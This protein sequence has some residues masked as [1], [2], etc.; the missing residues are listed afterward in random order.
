M[1]QQRKKWFYFKDS[2][3]AGSGRRADCSLCG[4][5]GAAEEE[6]ASSYAMSVKCVVLTFSA[7]F[8]VCFLQV[9][10]FVCF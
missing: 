9:L 3:K 2:V 8:I 1:M 10:R 5:W 7:A 6:K 4:K